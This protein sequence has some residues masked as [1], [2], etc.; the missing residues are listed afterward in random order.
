MPDIKTTDVSVTEKNSPE[1]QKQIDLLSDMFRLV[2]SLT[3]ESERASVILAAARLDVDL[4]R[5]LKHLL[6]HHPGGTDPMFEGDRLLGTFS[7]KI[8]MAY[9]LGAISSDLEHALQ[10]TRKIRNDFAHQLEGE[11]LSTPRQKARLAELVRAMETLE[12]YKAGW[13][14]FEGMA[15]S[16]EHLQFVLCT[17]CMTLCLGRAPERLHRVNVGLPLSLK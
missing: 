3:D 6:H 5:L 8:A 14:A 2:K 4:E 11:R 13:K 12:V 16:V 1:K 7:A 10:L 15:K 9:R 17:V